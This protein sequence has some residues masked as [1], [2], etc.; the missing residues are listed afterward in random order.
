VAEDA[1]VVREPELVPS[2]E[3]AVGVDGSGTEASAICFAFEEAALR[4]ARLHV[5]HAWSHPSSDGPG[6]MCPLVYD[7]AIVGDEEERAVENLLVRWRAEFPEVEVCCEAVHDRP[8]RALAGISARSEL[9]VVG[10]RGRGG[11]PGLLL[12]SVS[13]A[14]LHSA[15]CPVA[16]VP[17]GSRRERP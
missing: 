13:H 6:E 9:L 5:I 2:R 12:G 14:M 1:V 7:P 16:V 10:T 4:K 3:I 17:S 15:H 11:F 8:T